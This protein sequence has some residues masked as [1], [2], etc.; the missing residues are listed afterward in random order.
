MSHPVI[1]SLFQQLES[2][3]KHAQPPAPYL[4]GA[5]VLIYGAGN[6]GKELFSLLTR[7]GVPVT[8]FL[9]RAAQPGAAWH[10]VPIRTPDDT[11]IPAAERQAV[12]VV[13]GIFNAYVEIPPIVRRLHQLG[14]GRVTSFLDLHD[15][16]AAELGDR[17]WL[18]ARSR[19]AGL[20]PIIGAA[21]ELWADE[22]SRALYEAILRFRFTQAYEALPAPEQGQQYFPQALPP[23]RS[24]VRFVDCGAYDGDTLAQLL[25]T[26]LPLEAIAAFEPDPVN[27]AKLGHY[28]RAHRAALPETVCLFPCGVSSSLSQARFSSGQGSGSHAS[29]AG[30]TLIQCVSL[31]EALPQFR[32]TLIKMDIEGAEYGALWGARQLITEHRPGLAVCLYHRPEDLWQ[33]P[34]LVRQFCP[35]GRYYLRA[36]CFN[37]FDSVLYWRPD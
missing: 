16:F 20:E 14:Y 6:V 36:H 3:L 28:T 29:A 34:L 30:Q 19:Y 21:Y 4:E 24:P 12:H 33:I 22:G 10:G 17:F 31:D 32:P 8:G 18:T 15:R 25:A 9:D 7:Q 26:G 35:G 2:A 11:S 23:W 37:G 5:P 13:M 1:R 27:Y